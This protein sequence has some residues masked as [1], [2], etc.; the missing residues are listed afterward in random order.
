VQLAAVEASFVRVAMR[1]ARLPGFAARERRWSD[2]TR[3]QTRASLLA[4]A[5]AARCVPGPSHGRSRRKLGHQEV[6]DAVEAVDA[7]TE[8]LRF[9]R[10]EHLAVRS[11]AWQL[12]A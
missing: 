2:H 8:R 6:P 4:K 12:P 3:Q 11:L 7:M 1:S 9:V 5:T 10:A